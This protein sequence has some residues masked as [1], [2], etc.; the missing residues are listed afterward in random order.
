MISIAEFEREY[1]KAI[2]DGTAAVFAGAG[3]GIESGYVNWKDL[4]RDFAEAINLDVERENDLIEV[5]QFYKNEKGNRHDINNKILNEFLSKANN[6]KTVDTL[7]SLPISCYWT[8]NYDHLLEDALKRYGQNTDVKITPESLSVSLRSDAVTVYKMHGDCIDPSNCVLTK[9]DYETYNKYRNL[10]SIALQGQLVTKTFLFIGFSFDDPNLKYILSR[11][12]ILIGENVRN[13]YC[14][15]EKITRKD[16]Q[17]KK[18]F[19]YLKNKQE[20]KIHD[21]QRY[22]IQAVMLDSYSQIPKILEHIRLKAK[23][24]NIFIS[25]AAHNYGIKWDK[26]GTNLI[27]SLSQFFYDN[28]YK[29]ITGHARGV[30]SYIIS[31]ILENVQKNKEQLESHLL[32]RAFPYEDKS[33]SNYDNIKKKYRNDIAEETGIAIF[34][35]GNKL[36]EKG[37]VV[38]AEGMWEEYEIALEH[39][40]YI[41][42]V[43]TTGFVAKSIF[44]DVSKNRD[45]FPY[46]ST[47]SFEILGNSTNPNEI[48]CEIKKI[49]SRIKKL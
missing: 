44:E 9:D 8:T 49:L 13:H 24:K 42:P 47:E 46:L 22:G 23:T 48:V 25:G 6:T 31:T 32:I 27:T 1:I 28:E 38:P 15:F 18:D 36:N 5:A 29:I 41:I 40:L 21:L 10:F 19:E 35:F 37:E 33:N 12:R 26:L 34:I 16:K 39:N 45:Q 30:G 3:I 7:A 43:G 20:L 11:I 4:L 17:K 14:F 2:Q